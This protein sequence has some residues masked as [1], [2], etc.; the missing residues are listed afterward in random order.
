MRFI[1]AVGEEQILTVV[2]PK[3]TEPKRAVGPHKVYEW[4]ELKRRTKGD[5]DSPERF[6][7]V[8]GLASATR[9]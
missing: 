1:R 3:G 9:F 2:R 4:P 7:N 8:V 5:T 6:M